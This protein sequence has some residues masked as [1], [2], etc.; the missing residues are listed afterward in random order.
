MPDRITTHISPTDGRTYLRTQFGES[1]EEIAEALRP[2]IGRFV[3]FYP[4]NM[5]GH[6]NPHRSTRGWIRAVDGTKVT[7]YVPTLGYTAEVDAGEAFGTYCTVIEP[8]KE[9]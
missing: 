3:H 8:V 2:Y 1:S 9:D 6:I 5:Y 7:V 4:P